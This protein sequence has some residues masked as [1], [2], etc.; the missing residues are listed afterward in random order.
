MTETDL[1]T[2]KCDP[3]KLISHNDPIYGS[4][5]SFYKKDCDSTLSLSVSIYTYLSRRVFI[6]LYRMST[7]S[8]EEIVS[9]MEIVC[10]SSSSS[11]GLSAQ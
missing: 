6:K 8:T 3:T 4:H 1:W 10:G 2:S 7:V 9:Q 11:A 5:I